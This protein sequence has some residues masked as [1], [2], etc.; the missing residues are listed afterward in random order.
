MALGLSSK[1]EQALNGYQYI[2]ARDQQQR[3]WCS[4]FELAA[5]E[6]IWQYVFYFLTRSFNLSL[7][8]FFR[9]RIVIYQAAPLRFEAPGFEQTRIVCQQYVY[10]E[11]VCM[12]TN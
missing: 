6:E 3:K 12:Y 4:H 7:S 11:Y 9:L 8:M 5:C 2:E 10:V 1:E